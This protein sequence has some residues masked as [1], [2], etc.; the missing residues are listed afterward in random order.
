MSITFGKTS[1]AAGELSP[2]LWGQTELSKFKIGCSTLRNMFVGI[3]GGAYSRPG[4]K[5]C[6]QAFQ[7]AFPGVAPPRLIAFQFKT[8]QGYIIE[9]GNFYA[10]FIANGSYITDTPI[11][12]S[13]ATRANPCVLTVPG[14]NY[15]NG[16]WVAISG[17]QGM[18]QLDGQTFVVQNVSGNSFSLTDTFGNPVNSLPF[19]A[20][21]GAGTAA[22]IYTIATPWADDD[23]DYLKFTQSADVMTLTLSNPISGNE[24][25][26][27]DLDRLAANNWS[28]VA[29]S[30][31]ASIN[32]PASCTAT[33]TTL[34]SSLSSANNAPAAQYA[35]CVTA[36]DGQ[37]GQESIASPIGYTP[38]SSSSAASVDISITAGSVNVTWP[39]VQG[40]ASYNIYR[41]PA[42]V[43]N[44]G[45][46]GT[47]TPQSV[48]I[49][50]SF[51]YIGSSY[52]TQ[53]SDDN[54]VADSTQTPPLHLDPFA[55]GQILSVGA[56]PQTGTFTQSTTTASITTST[57]SGAVILPVVVNSLVAAAIVVNS[58]QS[59]TAADTVTFTDSSSHNS[60]TATLDVGPQS[61]NYPG[62]VFY[63]QQR[64]GYADSLNDPDTYWLS[65]TGAYANMDAAD[66]PLDSDAVTGTPWAQQV[67][68]IQWAV[69]M[70]AGLLIGTGLDAWILE[71][72]SGPA[73]A[74]TPSSQNAVPQETN[75]FAPTV[76]PIKINYQLLFVQALGSYV[77]ALNYN[78]FT[79][80]YA[81]DDLS[82]L[83]N[84]LFDG[85]QILQ[86]AWARE[87]YKIIWA[88][89]DDGILLSLTYLKDQEVIGWAR[90][91]TNGE[92][93]SIATASE[94]PVDAVYM[95]VRRFIQ[96]K[97]RY[98]YYVERMDNRIWDNV[99]D[100]WCVDA[101]LSLLLS[102][103][104]A[105]L[106]ASSAT[107][108]PVMGTPVLINGGQN[109]S[110]GTQY[111]VTDPTGGG[112][113]FALTI[114]SGAITQVVPVNPGS[115]YTNP[116]GQFV[117]PLGT[118]SEAVANPVIVDQVM[119]TA[120]QPVFIGAVP[121]Q[122]VRM[123]GGKAQVTSVISSTQ[124]LADMLI[125][126]T[127][128]TPDDPTN[129]PLQAG[130]GDWTYSQAVSSVSGLN[131]LEGMQVTGLADGAVIPPTTVVNG[132]IT[133]PF[134]ATAVT[135]GLGFQAQVQSLPAEI[136]GQPT[137]QGKRK[138]IS[139]VTV[140]LEKSRGVKLGSDQPNASQMENYAPA[141]WGSYPYGKM[142]EIPEI[143]NQ[144]GSGSYIPLF[145]GDRR[146]PIDGDWN[147]VGWS[148]APG[149]AAA[150][151]DYPL[152][153]TILAFD[154]EISV[155]DNNS[156]P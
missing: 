103:P 2:A 89:R 145:T 68:G 62:V 39:A 132:A 65:Q 112:A 14:H 37:T 153:M 30:Y 51:G 46:S 128:V 77:R 78:Y 91:D 17:V 22:R 98:A 84:H 155:G 121:G 93:I 57:G 152:P 12:L 85:R 129:T 33:P 34:V 127:A 126:I 83:S 5:F 18:T 61:G 9:L 136:P 38:N 48:P 86:W 154:P 119:F 53:F 43:W 107:G 118:G 1:F 31:S 110:A 74:V 99:E 113:T 140:R 104:S 123:G 40:A 131:H 156:P 42:A 96:G 81:G 137:I 80:T 73:T 58:G 106:S 56:I 100:A 144:I 8:D 92:V 28:L 10:R 59:Y 55:P 4:T 97:G 116:T 27:Q 88:V 149:M 29:E 23:L 26:P 133:L 90:H 115:G 105:T 109:Y 94:P 70:P 66:P 52:G 11:A 150:Q 54:I 79:N 3:R 60:V 16:D 36:I 19:T 147:L 120:D 148:A 35:Y 76:P 64:R 130:P 125:P 45:S 101:G 142:N 151:Q 63:F 69:P 102:T 114:S 82:V 41:A 21:T 13:G 47:A 134:P 49:G 135:V 95:V 6:G 139:A 44:T 32:P 117:D 124:L 25:V 67:N 108:D 122:I 146:I 71:G 24:Y 20:Y 72:S 138:K 111:V 50:S 15:A 143:Q 141:P 75:G 7:P 87:P